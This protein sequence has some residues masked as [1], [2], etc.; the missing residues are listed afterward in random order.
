MVQILA[1][2]IT[3]GLALIGV[4]ITVAATVRK[5]NRDILNEMKRQSE[6]DDA[7]LDAKL[8]KFQAVTDTKIEELTR[9]VREHN[10]F[11]RRLPVVENDVKTIY[12]RLDRIEVSGNDGK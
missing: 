12:K 9:E 4:I 6:M 2:A 3:G 8:E 10:N 11:A 1:A 7:R 5:G